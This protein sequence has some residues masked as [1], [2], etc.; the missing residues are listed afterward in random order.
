MFGAPNTIPF[1]ENL[2]GELRINC[3]WSKLFET[4]QTNKDELSLKE[5]IVVD[6][7]LSSF[8]SEHLNLKCV[9]GIDFKVAKAHLGCH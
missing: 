2:E 8:R 4:P 6:F 5:K 1:W 7:L 3:F 9:I